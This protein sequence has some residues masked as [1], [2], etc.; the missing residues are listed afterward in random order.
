MRFPAFALFFASF[1]KSLEGRTMQGLFLNTA[2][3]ELAQPWWLALLL[4]LPFVWWLERRVERGRNAMM[5]PGVSRLKT[6]G[7]EA[8]RWVR[9][10]RWLVRS[11]IVLAV[12]ATGRPQIAREAAAVSEKGIDIILALDISESMLEEDFGGS[13]LDAAKKIALRFMKS[14][15]QDRVGLV[16]FRGKSFTQCPLTLDHKLLGTL[17]RQVSV[18][19]VSDEGTAIGSAI[20]MGANRL[21]ASVSRERVLVLLTDGEHNTG[22]VGPVTAAGIAG[23]LGVRIYV[24]QVSGFGN[25]DTTGS[26]NEFQ[27]EGEDKDELLR[28]AASLTGGN[29]FSASDEKALGNAFREIDAL[30]RNRSGGPRMVVRT[31]LYSWFLL[32]ALLSLLA[33]LGLGSTRLLRVP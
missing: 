7:T 12:L 23:S 27:S 4:L 25:P 21:K 3:F 30:E 32:P 13:R 6:E 2:T 17:L 29:F 22:R 31:E 16:L 10:P 15:P 24:I 1:L 9:L 33:G 19:A 8:G 11:A 26:V 18:D 20:L 14:R 28:R 5:F